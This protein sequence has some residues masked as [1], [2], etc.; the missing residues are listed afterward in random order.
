MPY[1]QMVKE[2][3]G[4]IPPYIQE[5]INEAREDADVVVNNLID[6]YESQKQEK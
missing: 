2:E 3:Q 6:W 5:S 4:N 1:K